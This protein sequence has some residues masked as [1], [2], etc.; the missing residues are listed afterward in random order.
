M[1]NQTPRPPCE[2]SISLTLAK[3]LDGKPSCTILVPTGQLITYQEQNGFTR[4]RLTGG[5]II[6]VREGTAE[7]DRL[8]RGN[9][10]HAAR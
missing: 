9:F 2:Q 10:K 1:L 7:I 8:V 6:E 4:L 3:A 5:R